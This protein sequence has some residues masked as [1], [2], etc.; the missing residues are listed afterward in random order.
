ML[1]MISAISSPEDRDLMAEFY[2]KNINLLFYEARKHLHVEEDVEDI[3]FEAF[4]KLIE[5]IDV[6]RTLQPGQRARYG[7]VTVR[8]L[9]YL[10]IRRD[11]KL[12]LVSF[13]DLNQEPAAKETP[14]GILNQKQFA[15]QLHSVIASLDAETQMLLEQKY[16]LRW[17]DAEMALLYD[18]QPQSMRMKLTRA[19][20]TLLQK[21]QA[22][23]LQFPNTMN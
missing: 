5:K 18:V 14:E 21:M 4:E 8:N 7:V 2:D 15:D 1:V 11:S 19:K 22:Q 9:C 20:Q 23:D 6:L 12:S 13:E 17:T 3:V 16:I 10:H